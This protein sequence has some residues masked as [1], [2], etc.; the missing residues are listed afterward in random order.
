MRENCG[1]TTVAR[2]TR[3][4]QAMTISTAVNARSPVRAQLSPADRGKLGRLIHYKCVLAFGN[5][6]KMKKAVQRN[7]LPITQN[8]SDSS[9]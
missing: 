1:M 5:I 3:T 6:V 9:Q 8:Y 4:R 7:R 2:I